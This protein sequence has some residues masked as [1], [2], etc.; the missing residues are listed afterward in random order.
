MDWCRR[1]CIAACGNVDDYTIQR[2]A[3]AAT[4]LCLESKNM[5]NDEVVS[6]HEDENE[7]NVARDPAIIRSKTNYGLCTWSKIDLLAMAL[8][9]FLAQEVMQNHES[10]S[11]TAAKI[12]T[13]MLR[14]IVSANE[15]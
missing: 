10:S 13:S 7:E 12:D 2:N 4:V 14:K 3:L 11:Q 6:L 5:C 15:L 9:G 1:L 8:W